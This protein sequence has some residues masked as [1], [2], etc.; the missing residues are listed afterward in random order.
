M[1]APRRVVLVICDGHRPDFVGPEYCPAIAGLAGRGRWFERHRGIFPSVTR[2]SSASIAT[3]CP[4]AKHGLHGNRMA[5]A[6]GAGYAVHDAGRPDFVARM[7]RAFG[8]TP[9]APTLAVPTLAERLA[10]VGGAVVYSN[11]SPGAAYF[12]DPDGHGHVYHRAGVLGPGLVPIDTDFPITPDIAGDAAMT[13]RF[14]AEV[15]LGRRPALAVLWL[16]NPDKTMHANPLGSPAHLAAIRAADACVARVAAAVAGL[17]AEGEAVALLVGS[18]HGQET[19]RRVV[20]VERL[21]AEA[22]FKAAP[23]SREIVVATQGTAAL[24]YMTEAAAGAQGVQALAQWLARQ[25]WCGAVLDAARLGA[26]GLAAADGLR[27]GISMAKDDG[28]NAYGV[29]GLSDVAV[30][31]D[32][33]EGE[34]QAG[35]GQHGGLGAFEQRPFLVA[36]GPGFRAGSVERAPSSIL[37]IAPTVLAHLGHAADGLTGRPLQADPAA[38]L[39]K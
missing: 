11:V 25:D 22:G 18:D 12:Q 30:R 31:F 2:A 13:E 15:V 4:P 35:N 7:R 23:D 39:R 33:G 21:I 32:A 38:S 3:G 20:P 9:G 29:P 24:V 28:V 6:D 8:R 26:V 34:S 5:L 1:A 16:A 27:L 10:E 37:D 14:C 19:T 36:T 17:R